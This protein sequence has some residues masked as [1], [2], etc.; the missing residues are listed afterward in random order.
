MWTNHPLVRF[1]SDSVVLEDQWRAARGK[2]YAAG[3]RHEAQKDAE[4]A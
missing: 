2:L 4:A 3:K 1:V